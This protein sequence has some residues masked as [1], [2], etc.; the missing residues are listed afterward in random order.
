MPND[1]LEA[2]FT[3][4]IENRNDLR[5]ERDTLQTAAHALR[6]KWTRALNSEY[7]LRGTAEDL[8]NVL[9]PYLGTFPPGVGQEGPGLTA[10]HSRLRAAIREAE[11]EPDAEPPNEAWEALVA[12]AYAQ[13]GD[14]ARKLQAICSHY[15]AMRDRLSAWEATVR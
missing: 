6:V 9:E 15:N 7:R 13:P 2:E 1:D 8:L 3:A 5:R 10:L 4:L 12:Y 11:R 14:G